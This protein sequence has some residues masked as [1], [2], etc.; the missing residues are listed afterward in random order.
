M[1][2]EFT[3]WAHRIGPLVKAPGVK[4]RLVLGNSTHVIDLAFYLGGL[5]TELNAL[6][7]GGLEW[8]P[9]WLRFRGERR[10]RVRRPVLLPR[11]LDRAGPVVG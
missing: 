5:P 9:Q 2:F 3:E 6:V 10:H 11:R 1:V 8:H 7:A 4:E